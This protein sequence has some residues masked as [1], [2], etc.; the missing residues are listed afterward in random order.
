[1]KRIALVFTLASGPALAE[2]TPMDVLENWRTVYAGSGEAISYSS[3]QAEPDGKG[4][5]LSD[6]SSV[7][8]ITNSTTTR[9]FDWV[10][11][12]PNADGG[13]LIT[14]SPN[15]ESVDVTRFPNGT[16]F[17]TTA[18]FD[19][20]ALA[21][22][23]TG[24]PSDVRYSYSAPQVTY[25]EESG[26][27]DFSSRMEITITD[28]SGEETAITDV[29]ES[30][31]RVVDFEEYRF[32]KVVMKTESRS[33]IDA[34]SVTQIVASD[35]TATFRWEF[36]LKD[37][38]EAP[39][40]MADLPRQS[41]LMMGIQTGSLSGAISKD[42]TPGTTWLSFGQNSGSVNMQFAQN[43]FRVEVASQGSTLGMA[44]S[45]P[46]RPFDLALTELHANLSMPFR[47]EPNATPF[48]AAFSL[49]G[50]ALDE[51]SW[52]SVDPENSMGRPAADISAALSGLMQLT[53]GMFTR[54][55]LDSVDA[56]FFVPE[57]SL[58]TL[59]V[60]AG[61]AVIEGQGE[62]RFDPRRHDPD[63]DMPMAEGALDFSIVGALGF[64]DRFGRLSGVDPLVVLS[65]KGG[66]GMFASPTDAP[67]NF[68][69]R[70][71]FLS[72]DG[73]VVNGQTVR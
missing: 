44:A 38:P 21:L 36:P 71:E 5:L 31:P 61:G 2:I 22:V 45:A 16:E 65:A 60:A 68:T 33:F 13:I 69:S 62:L 6:V 14:F 39:M 26:D 29:T 32:G 49:S 12:Q 35:V 11:M 46:T 56:P 24:F 58:D 10:R 27:A 34:P 72:G 41:D 25:S 64:L 3:L 15:G 73:I 48:S 1:M 63:T 30:G 53:S 20:S 55:S 52:A 51:A 67:D 59:R 54:A 43:Q 18:R 37:I 66:L 17:T 8:I 40:A 50:L 19:F 70:V 23:A 57:L 7:S 47:K 4:V 9:H 42:A 28:L